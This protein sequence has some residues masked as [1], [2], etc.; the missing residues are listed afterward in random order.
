MYQHDINLF[1][2]VCV[3]CMLIYDSLRYGPSYET[4][5][6]VSMIRVL[7]GDT[8]GMSTVHEVVKKNIYIYHTP[9]NPLLIA[10]IQ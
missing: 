9:D 4:P 10:L 1:L 3:F 2:C 8:V 7:G 5:A 6:E